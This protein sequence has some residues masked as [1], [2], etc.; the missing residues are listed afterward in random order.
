MAKQ[1]SRAAQLLL[2]ALDDNTNPLGVVAAGLSEKKAVAELVKARL[3]TANVQVDSDFGYLARLKR[4][5]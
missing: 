5:R 3:V 4:V 2:K 1:L